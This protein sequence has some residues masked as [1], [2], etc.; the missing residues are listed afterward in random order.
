MPN[1][2][3]TADVSNVKGVAGGYAYSAPLGTSLPT[4]SAPFATLSGF[5]NLGFVSDDGIEEEK[6]SD[7][8]KKYD[9]NGDLIAVLK[10]TEDETLVF[11]LCNTTVAALKEMHGHKNVTSKT[12][13]IE[14]DHTIKDHDERSYVFDLLLKDGRRLRKVVPN[15]LVTEVGT[16]TYVSSE[17]Y[18]REI[19]VSCMPD[20]DGVRIY[21]YIQKTATTTTTT[22]TTGE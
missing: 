11:T 6:D 9:L 10:S 3:S 19:T 15:G 2:N 16:I 17:L 1:A 12:D 21:D 18:A 22:T 4:E 5:D 7:S 13:F 8:E 14:I 20:S